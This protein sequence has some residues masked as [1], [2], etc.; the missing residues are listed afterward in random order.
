MSHR[1]KEFDAAIAIRKAKPDLRAL[2][3]LPDNHVVLLFQL[4]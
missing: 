2:L 1:R 3:M 4:A